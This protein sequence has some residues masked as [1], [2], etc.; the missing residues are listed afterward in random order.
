MDTPGLTDAGAAAVVDLTPWALFM[1][2]DLISRLV[3]IVL[4]VASV[5]SWAIIIDKFLRMR[6]IRAATDA[7]ENEFW[8]G[9]SLEGLYDRVADRPDNPMAVI[10]VSAM[11]EW[12]RSVERGIVQKGLTTG[13]KERIDKVMTVTIGREMERME[14]FLGFLAS[15]GSTAPFV[16]LMGTVWGIMISFSQIASS[17]NNSLAVVAPG[18][19]HALFATL[20]GLVA[21]IPAVLAYNVL[22]SNFN[23]YGNRL[24]GFAD[25]FSA[26]LSR[27]LD[28]RAK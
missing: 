16:G 17:K 2:G 26:I 23:R 9:G 1:H 19:S 14:R 28:E 5:W 4:I 22:Q 6:R 18:I 12:R 8:A 20:L 15:V 21:A 24:D 7:F 25:E 10:F 27:Q 13:L 3:M 11:G